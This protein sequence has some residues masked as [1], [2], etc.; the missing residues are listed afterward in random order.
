VATVQR[1]RFIYLYLYLMYK[2]FCRCISHLRAAPI[3]MPA[4]LQRFLSASPPE[5]VLGAGLQQP[6]PLE[7][8]GEVGEVSFSAVLRKAF[9]YFT[10]Y[11]SSPLSLSLSLSTLLQSNPPGHLCPSSFAYSSSYAFHLLSTS[12]FSDARQ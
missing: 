11:L 1:T 9:E 6:K 3:G 8:A 7:G 10:L 2:L 4:L 5:P 12:T